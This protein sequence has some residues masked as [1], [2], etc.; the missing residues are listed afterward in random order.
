MR[1]PVLIRFAPEVGRQDGWGRLEELTASSARLSTAS[2]L[3]RGEKVFL[4]FQ[5]DAESFKS[6]PAEVLYEEGDDD[7]YRSAELRFTDE[8]A[9]RRLARA[10]IDVLSR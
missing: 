4:S 7:G 2:A 8:V 5:L 10:L 1:L 9:K 3:A 6:L